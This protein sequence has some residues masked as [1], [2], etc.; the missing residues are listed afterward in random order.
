M[1]HRKVAGS[2]VLPVDD[3]HGVLPMGNMVSALGVSS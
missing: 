2:D 1:H 3:L